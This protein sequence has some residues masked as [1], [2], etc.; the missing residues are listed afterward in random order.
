METFIVPAPWDLRGDSIIQILLIP[1]EKVRH[2]LPQGYHVWSVGRMTMGALMWVHYTHS[3]VG[4]YEEFIFLPARV[5]F[6]KKTGYY[7]SHIWVNSVASLES[8]RS[9]W[10]IPKRLGTMTY[11][12]KGSKVHA[13]LSETELPL[14]ALDA[15]IPAFVPPVP[16]HS[17]VFSMPLIQEHDGNHLYVPYG[18]WGWVRPVK[19][20]FTIENPTIV[21]VPPQ[22]R[23]LPAIWLGNFR[24]HFPVGMPTE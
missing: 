6:E 17:S 5:T 7:M 13:T 19:A 20:C 11:T 12:R 23:R 16:M 9:N 18:G 3:P 1:Y 15:S 8:G 2:L 10:W 24:M 14:V 21:P 22:S 4:P